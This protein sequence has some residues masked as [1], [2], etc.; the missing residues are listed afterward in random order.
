MAEGHPR[1]RGAD[2]EALRRSYDAVAPEYHARLGA[3]LEYKPWDRALLGALVEQAGPGA[4]VADLGCGPG[5]VTAFLAARGARAVGIDLSPGMVELARRLHPEAEF[6]VG[7]LVSL[8]AADGEFAAAVALYS[9]IHLPEDE[10]GAAL[11]EMRRVLRPGAPL[12]V[13]FHVGSEVRHRSEWWG[14]AV[15][16][17]FRFLPTG[18]VAAGLEAAGL[19]VELS[20]ERLAHAEEV[21]TRRAYLAARRRAD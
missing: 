12:L 2:R 21:D 6:R 5:H 17:D 7:D 9:L 19:T 14:E 11:G 15:D 16:L 18:R 20:L 8:P 1:G 13:A 10:L 4:M 3:E